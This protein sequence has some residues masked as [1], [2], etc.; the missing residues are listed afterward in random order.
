ML[1]GLIFSFLPL[2]FSSIYGPARMGRAHLVILRA[3]A[4]VVSDGALDNGII[5]SES[6]ITCYPLSRLLPERACLSCTGLL[7]QKSFAPRG[8]WAGHP[9]SHARVGL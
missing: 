2:D 9:G 8:V 7:G 5:P 1:E 6:V 3:L 4:N